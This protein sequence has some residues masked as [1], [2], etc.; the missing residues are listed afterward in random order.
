VGTKPSLVF[1]VSAIIGNGPEY[2]EE[3]D[4]TAINS[5]VEIP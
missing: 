4:D 2:D 5:G 1:A 3:I